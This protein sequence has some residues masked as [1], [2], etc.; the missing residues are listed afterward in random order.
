MESSLC[1]PKAELWKA[2]LLIS[3]H[4]VYT[5]WGNAHGYSYYTAMSKQLESFSYSYTAFAV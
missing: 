1:G 4:T 2:I 5:Q 3:D